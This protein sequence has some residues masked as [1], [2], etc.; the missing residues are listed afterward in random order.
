MKS[1]LFS[2]FITS[3]VKTDSVCTLKMLQKE[4]LDDLADDG[5]LN[6]VRLPSKLKLEDF[7][8]KIGIEEKKEV[9]SK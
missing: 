6:C 1:I 4:I 5:K 9:S 2:I 3:F 7:I 8:I